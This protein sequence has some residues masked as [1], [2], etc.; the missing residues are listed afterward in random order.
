M[1]QKT[2]IVLLLVFIASTASAITTT[3]ARRIK[4][5]KRI[6]LE[7]TEPAMSVETNEPAM[8]VE[9]KP[10]PYTPPDIKNE[11][12]AKLLSK[13]AADMSD[14]CK[15]LVMLMGKDKDYPGTDAQ[16]A[17]LKEKGVF[18]KGIRD[19]VY[20]GMKLRKGVAAYMFCR[21]VGIK[22]GVFLTL[23]GTTERYAMRE[24][25]Y[26]GIMRPGDASD[27]VTGR[28]L[29]LMVIGSAEYISER[30]ISKDRKER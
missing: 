15:V 10:A 5:D 2:L 12:F 19:K 30:N 4:E 7:P 25:I 24:L 1:K 16:I 18:P 28:E 29:T 3:S 26:E 23:L 21:A 6:A 13:R 17:F 8:S 22:G 14:A 9:T 20:P 11:Y 27:L